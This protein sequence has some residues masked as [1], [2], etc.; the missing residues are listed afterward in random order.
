M[1]ASLTILSLGW[2][3]QSWTLAAMA[4]LGELPRP[5]VAV[6]SDTTFEMSHTYAFAEEWTPWLEARGIPVVTVRDTRATHITKKSSTSD[7][8]YTLMPVFTRNED[9]SRGQLRRQCTSRWKIEPLHKWLGEELKR[10]GI[11]KAD[12][13]VEQWLGISMDEW[14]RMKTSPVDWI[15][16][17]YPLVDR[18]LSRDDCLRWLGARGLPSPGR[19]ACKQCP[20]RAPASWVELKRQGGE[21]WQQ[22]LAADAQLRATGR[23]WYLHPARVPLGDAVQSAE[24]AGQLRLWDDETDPTCDSGHCFL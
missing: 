2:G 24:D 8:T 12:G 15:V 1:S 4:A 11:A 21:D 5:D 3:V 13:V 7:G 19:S 23:P 6:H 22:A 16:N 17:T 18:R 20:Y 9:G 14:H 10:R